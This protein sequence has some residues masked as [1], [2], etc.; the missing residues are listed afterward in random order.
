MLG[1]PMLR[2]GHAVLLGVTLVSAGQ[3]F[4]QSA[5]GVPEAPVAMQ[6]G[7]TV[8]N[9]VRSWSVEGASPSALGA[10]VI[11][12]RD[13]RVVGQAVSFTDP[14]RNLERATR[15]AMVRALGEG[16]ASLDNQPGQNLTVEVELAGT[17][18]PLDGDSD[19]S[20]TLGVNPGLDGVA[21]RL[22]ERVA[23]RFPSQMRLTGM[24]A[25]EAARAL[26]SEVADDATRGL[27]TIADLR[28]AGY[29]FYRFRTVDLVQPSPGTGLI[30]AHR[31]GRLVDKSEITSPRLRQ[32]ADGMAKHLCARLWP[33]VEPYGL[34]GT[35]D[36]LTGRVA[37]RSESPA[38]QA[39]AASALLRYTRTAGVDTATRDTAR[40]T[41]IEILR[42]LAQV[43][44]GETEPWSNPADAAAT[45]IALVDAGELE[46]EAELGTMYDR[47]V[48]RVTPAYDP[49]G[50]VFTEDVP[51][52][53]WGLIALSLVRLSA[54]GSVSPEIAQ[55][56]VRAAFR[57][58]PP[59]RLVGQLPWLGWAELESTPAGEP[60]PS[61]PTL[62]ETR[63]LIF[64]HQ[65]DS[66]TLSPGDRD[67]AGGIVFTVGTTPLPTWQTV[68]PLPF[69]A[70]MLADDRLSGG[71]LT[72][73]EASAELTHLLASI[74][75]VHQLC[76]GQVEGCSYPRPARAAWGVRMA[77]WDQRMSIEATALGLES[78][79][80][81]ID[82]VNALAARSSLEN[83]GD[84]APGG[85][86]KSP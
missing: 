24:T 39:L 56:A 74:R 47:C 68:R 5:D 49:R 35:L 73:G 75:F 46:A 69:L 12:R 6:A 48:A 53:A 84:E 31:G 59:E 34:M 64:A 20:L 32:M 30:F 43:A 45:I 76:A 81:T 3:S 41:A 33:G 63:R 51:E 57:F 14:A 42:E 38:A 60:V 66:S 2:A 23:G 44:E 11:L 65:L 15:L 16:P 21:V 67:L 58:T 85:L 86:S 7:T 1:A 27:D 10:A 9:W 71:T 13:G 70:D 78:V 82:A 61:A 40:T 55:G 22:G 80:R 8:E 36:P 28:E 54:D 83:K 50:R 18:V 62:L 26:V 29:A 77:L 72:E 19:V 17:L 25:S 52:S 4:G 37:A 79:C